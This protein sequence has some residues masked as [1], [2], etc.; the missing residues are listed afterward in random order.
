M[1]WAGP[2]RWLGVGAGKCPMDLWI[3]QEIIFDV[4][5]DTIIECGTGGG[6]S[7]L[8]MASICDLI[9]KG[10]I[11]TIDV[12]ANPDRPMHERIYYHL[13][14]S[15]HPATVDLV[16]RMAEGIVLVDL[17]SA[18]DTPHVLKEMELYAPLVTPGSYLIVEDTNVAPDICPGHGPGPREAVE[19]FLKGNKSFVPDR[20]REKL[21]LTFNPG[22]YLRRI[23]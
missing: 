18:H 21:F 19:A 15:V 13:G 16:K 20:Q 2:T 4:K 12:A 14:S 10:K 9:G 8:F 11:I 17:D 7:T 5:P 22:G 1:I 3:F 23:A 6:G